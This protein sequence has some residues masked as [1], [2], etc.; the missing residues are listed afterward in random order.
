VGLMVVTH[1]VAGSWWAWHLIILPDGSPRLVYPRKKTELNVG[2]ALGVNMPGHGLSILRCD[3]L[4]K[5]SLPKFQKS[6]INHFLLSR[7]IQHAPS[8]QGSAMR[9]IPLALKLSLGT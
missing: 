2:I 9:T 6:K 5:L 4:C 7:N 3:L 1:E 8:L